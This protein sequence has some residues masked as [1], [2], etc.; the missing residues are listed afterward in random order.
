MAQTPEYNL[1]YPESTDLVKNTATYI[2]NLAEDT[3][4]AIK[5]KGG[6]SF[7]E[8]NIKKITSQIELTYGTGEVYLNYPDGFNDK[9]CEVISVALKKTT[10]N[11]WNYYIYNSAYMISAWLYDT[12]VYVSALKK[13]N[14]HNDNETLDVKVIL[15]KM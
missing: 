6:N 7:L 10:D 8:N 9:N 3:E 11:L 15:L 4:T 14:Q 5:T 12:N 13:D 1:R 2:Q